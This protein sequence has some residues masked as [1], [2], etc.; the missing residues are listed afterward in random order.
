MEPYSD[1]V[2]DHIRNPRNVGEIED[3]DGVGEVGNPVCGDVMRLYIKI[4]DNH[5]TDV[6]FQTFGCGAAIAVSSMLT[7]LVKGKTIEDALRI[8]NRTVAEALD[9]LPP[10]KMH[11][12]SLGEDALRAAI[13]DFYAKKGRM[14]CICGE[15]DCPHHTECE[16]RRKRQQDKHGHGDHDH[17]GHGDGNHEHSE[18][19]A[20]SAC[21]DAACSDEQAR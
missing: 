13:R 2:M 20:D 14:L 18:S 5:I 17:A 6:K 12:S 19:C 9:G 16:E 4:K 1:R 10:I 8:S 7:E 21:S 11:C 3:A 15:L